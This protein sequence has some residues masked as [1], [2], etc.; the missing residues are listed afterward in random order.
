MGPLADGYCRALR[1]GKVLCAR[2]HVADTTAVRQGE[3]GG[4]AGGGARVR[5]CDHFLEVRRR[6]CEPDGCVA[7]AALTLVVWH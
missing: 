5:L 2:Y 7:C 3:V 6:L 4:R 1:A